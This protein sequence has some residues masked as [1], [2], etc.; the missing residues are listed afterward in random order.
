MEKVF[1]K[2]IIP[3]YNNIQF[4][5]ECLDS[6]LNQTFT[7]YKIVIVDDQSTDC[8]DKVCEVYAKNNPDKIV[9]L[10]ANKYVTK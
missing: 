7:D 6:I 4:I 3:N 10:K 5:K 1:F 9:Y 8:S 2:I